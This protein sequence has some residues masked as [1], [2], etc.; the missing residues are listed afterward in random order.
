MGPQFDVSSERTEKQ[1]ID[2]VIPGL[3][4]KLVIHYTTAVPHQLV[5]LLYS[6]NIVC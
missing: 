6:L 3:V 5:P 2:H 4:I 1:G